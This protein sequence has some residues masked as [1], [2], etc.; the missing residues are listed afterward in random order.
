MVLPW[1]GF[2]LHSL[3]VAIVNHAS[4]YSVLVLE[5][6]QVLVITVGTSTNVTLSHL[7][8]KEIIGIRKPC[9][10]RSNDSSATTKHKPLHIQM[11]HRN[12]VDINGTLC[13]DPRL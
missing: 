6:I 1:N 9:I 11:L 7:R 5:D 8:A 13:F 10:A 12:V 4:H 2:S 3:Y